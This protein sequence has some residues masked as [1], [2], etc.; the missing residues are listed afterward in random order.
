M[1]RLS[2]RCPVSFLG[3]AKAWE[4]LDQV[5]VRV[6]GALLYDMVLILCS[7]SVS[8]MTAPQAPD[9]RQRT[10]GGQHASARPRRVLRSTQ[11]GHF[12][13]PLLLE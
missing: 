12:Q 3:P 13:L 6:Q 5:V 9:S 1:R 4:K 7:E 10:R 2:V 8:R 11:S